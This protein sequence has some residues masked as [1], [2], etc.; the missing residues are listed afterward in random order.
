MN[1]GSPQI[2]ALREQSKVMITRYKDMQ[3]SGLKEDDDS[4]KVLKSAIDKV[5]K[6]LIEL[7]LEAL[8]L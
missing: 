7:E 8:D 5:G 6:K 3:G 1:N 4:V 2:L